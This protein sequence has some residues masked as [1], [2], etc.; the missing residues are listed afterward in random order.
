[1]L[2]HA[3]ECGVQVFEGV[4]VQSIDFEDSVPVSA[5]WEKD[6]IKG[7]IRFDWIVDCTGRNGILSTK[8]LK[9]REFNA[10]LR[11]VAFWGYWTGASEYSPDTDRRNAPWFEALTG[12]CHFWPRLLI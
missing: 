4:Q 10:A 8:Y 9:N 6:G 1:M 5:V 12:A 11:N 7:T 2:R 3:S